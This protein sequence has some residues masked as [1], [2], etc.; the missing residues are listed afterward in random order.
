[1]TP[2]NKIRHCISFVI[3]RVFVTSIV[4]YYIFSHF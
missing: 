3:K 2:K 1:M 4:R